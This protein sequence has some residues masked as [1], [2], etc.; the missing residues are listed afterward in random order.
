[1]AFL[2]QGMTA[3]AIAELTT[4]VALE[5]YDYSVYRL[6]LGRV[7]LSA[8]RLQE[9]MATARQAA[10]ERDPADPR[11]DLELD[12]RRAL[13]LLAEVQLAMA[14]PAEAAAA[15]RE[16]LELWSGADPKLPDLVR[17]RELAQAGN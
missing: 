9:A 17:A 16:V 1:V 11:L 15:A 3:E 14:R 10:T 2:E 8:G 6:E 7:Y 5:G 4:A 13:L 12:R